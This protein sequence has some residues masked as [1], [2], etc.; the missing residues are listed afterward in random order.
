MLVLSNET[1]GGHRLLE[2]IEQRA[3]R[4]PIRCTIVCPRDTPHQGF[5]IY[6]DTARCSIA[7]SSLWPPTV[8]FERTSTCAGSWPC[9]VG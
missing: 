8:S 7:S 6:D 1:V 9:G 4:G 5:V 3:A 2:A